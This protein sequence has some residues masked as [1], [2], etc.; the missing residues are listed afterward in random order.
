MVLEMQVSMQRLLQLMSFLGLFYS[1]YHCW[2]SCVISYAV[3]VTNAAL[4][5]NAVEEKLPLLYVK[6]ELTPF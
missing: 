2:D 3:H 4:L 1:F 5:V 6:S